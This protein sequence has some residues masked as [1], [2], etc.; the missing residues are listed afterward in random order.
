[1]QN[2][3]SIGKIEYNQTEQLQKTGA[4]NPFAK[5][6]VSNASIFISKGPKAQA[7]NYTDEP[8]TS[9]EAKY[10]GEQMKKE[11]SWFATFTD[12][13]SKSIK[14]EKTSSENIKNNEEVQELNVET[15]AN[16]DTSGEAFDA[17]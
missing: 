1:M 7:Q 6:K 5:E 12:K 16:S 13:I 11:K 9:A 10:I 3:N 14:K 15:N 8:I 17:E 4:S 2:Y